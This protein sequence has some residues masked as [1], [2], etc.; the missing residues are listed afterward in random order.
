[1]N[2]IGIKEINAYYDRKD[3]IRTA[4][5]NNYANVSSFAKLMQRAITE[6]SV[7][8]TINAEAQNNHT[9]GTIQ[10]NS[11]AHMRSTAQNSSVEHA[12]STHVSTQNNGNSC[13]EQC[14]QTNQLMLQMMTKNLYTQS[15]LGYPLT[16]NSAWMAYQNMTGMLNNSLF[17]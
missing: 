8:A 9:H 17:A 6:R 10:S 2:N 13:C 11:A 3:G 15:I 1:M 12:E 4:G 7:T 16:G 5:I 14:H